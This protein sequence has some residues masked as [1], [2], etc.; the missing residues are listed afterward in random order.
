M[1]KYADGTTSTG[2]GLS[3]WDAGRLTHLAGQVAGIA[4]D[5]SARIL[6]IGCA[7][8]GL[9]AALQARGFTEVCG[10]DPSPDCVRSAAMIAPG[11]VWTGTL[12]QIPSGIGTFDG[13]ILSHVMEHVR[14]LR[15]AM[16]RL[17]AML[18][19]GGWIYI[20]VPDAAR[21]EQF[22]IAPF[23]DFNT[24]HIN[25]FSEAGLANLCRSR[26]F[27]PESGG[28]KDIFSAKDIPYPALY[29]FSRAAMSP[30]PVEKDAH[31]RRALEGYVQASRKLMERIDKTIRR[32][33]ERHS[34]LIVWGTGQL[35]MKL[36]ADTC[37]RE[38]NIVAFVDGNPVNQGKELLGRKVIGGAELSSGKTPILVCSLIN[39]SAI[40]AAIRNL[41]LTNP[42][43]G[44]SD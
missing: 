41:G 38:A 22:L 23:Q 44:L 19:P 29:L 42:V 32:S 12:S 14:D 34:D 9:L 2:A 21:Y 43:V 31:L 30:Q 4:L 40:I 27:A 11:R 26:G 3:Q 17:R 15:T 10:I 36:L 25:H 28:T 33:I 13:I 20:E 8:G 1:S 16:D 24:E 6:D 5:L 18:N 37:L 35:T 7:N 39:A